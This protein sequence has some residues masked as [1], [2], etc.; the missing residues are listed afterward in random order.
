MRGSLCVIAGQHYQRVCDMHTCA[1]CAP[2]AL[3][4]PGFRSLPGA[5]PPRRTELRQLL[6]VLVTSAMGPGLR[7]RVQALDVA[8]GAAVD[9]V[10]AFVP[11]GD[12]RLRGRVF[13][14]VRVSA[15]RNSGFAPGI[16]VVRA[17]ARA[18]HLAVWP[19]T[20][21]VFSGAVHR[22]CT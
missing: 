2:A 21:G 12:V 14:N 7:R 19:A 3:V 16:P 4:S 15:A 11:E 13:W 18:R 8:Q 20:A 6:A 17:G 10:P 1:A 5:A 22:G 9:S